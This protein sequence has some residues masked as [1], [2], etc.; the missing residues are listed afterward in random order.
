MFSIQYPLYNHHFGQYCFCLPQDSNKDETAR[1]SEEE[2]KGMGDSTESEKDVRTTADPKKNGKAGQ[3]SRCSSP[4]LYESEKESGSE[5][6]SR[7][8]VKTKNVIRDNLM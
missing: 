7:Y 1:S 4:E 6:A 5:E 2:E 3:D 8:T